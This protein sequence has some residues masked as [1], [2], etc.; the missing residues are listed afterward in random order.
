MNNLVIRKQSSNESGVNNLTF[1]ND[2]HQTSQFGDRNT[3]QFRS[4]NVEEKSDFMMGL[5]INPKNNVLEIVKSDILEC[6]SFN[7]N[8]IYNNSDNYNTNM[9]KE[10]EAP[11]KPQFMSDLLDSDID[12]NHQTNFRK[13]EK[14]MTLTDQTP[15][16]LNLPPPLCASNLVSSEIVVHN[17][18]DT[19]KQTG[20]NEDFSAMLINIG[21]PLGDSEV[22]V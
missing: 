22:Y 1:G 19:E 14:H 18:K 6:E 13:I 20:I 5:K 4:S 7:S 16:N 15:H 2:V 10:S 11:M 9:I 8:T 17:T 3:P 21:I 12:Q